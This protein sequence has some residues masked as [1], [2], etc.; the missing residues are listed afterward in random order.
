MSEQQSNHRSLFPTMDTLES[1]V[2]LGMS[3]LPITTPN[4]LM[5][6][7]NTYHNTLLKVQKE[8]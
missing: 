6:I 2:E 3:Q 5:S 7:L 4:A 1:V 8:S